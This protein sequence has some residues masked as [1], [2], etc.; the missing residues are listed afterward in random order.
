[1]DFIEIYIYFAV[2]STFNMKNEPS[3]AEELKTIRKIMEESTKFLSLSGLSGVF[4]GLLAIA[5]AAFAWFFIL[6]SGKEGYNEYI[7]SLSA[8]ATLHIRLQML[9]VALTVL[10]LSLLTAFY[11]SFR[12]AKKAG[13]SL[14]TPVSKRLLM[15]LLIP[16][17]TGAMFALI[18]MFQNYI[19]LIIPCLLI[20]Y[21]LA[22]VNGGKFTYNEVFYLGIFEIATGLVSAFF[23][24]LGLLFWIL[25]FGI[26]HIV[27]G[28]FMF[29]KYEI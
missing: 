23:P 28:L 1:L 11:F 4:P 8:E 17:V 20:F 7:T 5:G 27:Y 13:R 18:L 10:I 19:Q 24:S 14:W 16:L 26:L 9:A 12:R 3:S 25:G 22:L 29:R 2:Q 6:D 15:S 21:G